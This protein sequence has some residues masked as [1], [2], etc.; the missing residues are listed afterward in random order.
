MKKKSAR[1]LSQ[2]SR[3]HPFWQAGSLVTALAAIV[4]TFGC[5]AVQSLNPTD[6]NAGGFNGAPP[7]S[8]SSF[9]DSNS[10][11]DDGSGQ[12]RSSASVARAIEE[13]DIVK[14][15]GDKLFALNRFKGLLIVDVQN[16]DE[17]AL[18]GELD[19]KGRGVEMYVGDTQAYVLLSADYYYYYDGGYGFGD[20]G[21]AVAEGSN[22]ALSIAPDGPP[23]ERPDFDG[24]QLAII[25]ISDPTDPKVESKVNLV[26][27]ANESRRV[28][29]IIYV[30]GSNYAPYFAVGAEDAS[31]GTPGEGFVASV[32]VADPANVTPVE[33]KSLS[34]NAL[35]MHTS[36][37][38]IY[39]ASQST[40][41]TPATP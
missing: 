32:N 8:P 10:E 5:D 6:N 15:A 39:A 19:L 24:S 11:S 1:F 35:T 3:S 30:V 12:D 14:V 21:I 28:G 4:F 38:A 41:S 40:I 33:R 16:P 23:P 20:D 9:G 25:D 22:R 34:G 2:P 13:A 31:N 36:D 29:D 18:L 17:P 37:S 27:F 7:G 26:G